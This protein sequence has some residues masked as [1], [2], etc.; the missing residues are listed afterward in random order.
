MLIITT[1]CPTFGRGY[2]IGFDRENR[3]HFQSSNDRSVKTYKTQHGAEK[4]LRR[5]IAAS[6]TLAEGETF[7]IETRQ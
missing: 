6:G 3:A 2:F 1:Q 4:Q 5:I 7:S